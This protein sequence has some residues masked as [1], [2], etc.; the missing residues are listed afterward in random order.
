[1]P[2]N[3]TLYKKSG[4]ETFHLFLDFVGYRMVAR[5]ESKLIHGQHIYKQLVTLYHI[6]V[7]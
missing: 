1:M 3:V 5:Y 4:E 2:V 7:I 6:C